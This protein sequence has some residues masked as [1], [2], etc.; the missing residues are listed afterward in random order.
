MF[1]TISSRFLLALQY[2]D[3]RTLWTAN[4]LAGASAWALIVARGWLAYDLTGSSL[5][6]GLVTFMAM[7][8]RVFATPAIG[9]I[10]DR[11]DRQ[12][13]LSWTYGLNL[14]HNVALAVLFTM[15]M[16]GP[17]ALV[18][19]ALINGTLRTSQQTTTQSLVPNLVPRENLLNALALNE[20][21]QQGSRLLGPAAIAPLLFLL[22]IEA[23][24]WL[25][26]GFYLLGLIQTLR[27][28][29]RSRGNIDRSKSLS[30]NLLAGFN[31]VYSTP[32]VLAMVLLA[33]FHC[34]LT[35]S[36]ESLLPVLS[37][38]ALSAG[39]SGVSLL[40][41][42]VGAGVLASSVTLAGVRSNAIRGRLFLVLG[43]G[44]GIT[45]LALGV[46]TL[47][48]PSM[49]AAVLMG[50]ST[51]GFMTLTH[52]IIQTVVPDGVRGRVSGIYSMHVGGSMAVANLM[53]GA[54]SDWFNA[55]VVMAITGVGFVLAVSLSVA[56]FPLRQ[57]YFPRVAPE[58]FPA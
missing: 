4:L 1:Q 6:V 16:A 32:V 39:S 34:S 38:E 18:V 23:A 17:W 10:A 20:A 53:N 12:T 48:G 35:M 55:P 37:E 58:P 15:G 40:M 46:S 5:W 57:I 3:F 7:A 42:A 14:A 45:Y 43:V 29:T 44:S 56:H 19:L 11:F 41:A 54:L 13:V 36:Y 22:N 49:A 26:S 27:I 21:T 51:A 30:Q 52:T 47:A 24:L 9:F 2:R 31:Y 8:P 50:A 33:L 28:N 25:C